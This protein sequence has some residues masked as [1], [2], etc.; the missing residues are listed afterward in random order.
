MHL[1]IRTLFCALVLALALPACLEIEEEVEVAADGSVE[2]V[3]R[4]RGDAADLLEGYPVPTGGAWVA[5]D[6]GTAGWLAGGPPPVHPR[7]PDEVAVAVRARFASLADLPRWCA[8]DGEPYRTAGEERVT[9]LEV[10]RRGARTVY[11]FER[12]YPVKARELWNVKERIDEELPEELAN[13]LDEGHELL[14]SE[15]R[16]V[17]S[18]VQNVWGGAIGGAAHDALLAVY[19]EGRAELS[20]DGFQATRDAVRG[21]I[22][23]AL[24]EAC[25]RG[26]V[27]FV[28]RVEAEGGDDV[29]VPPEYDFDRVAR[30]AARRALP[31]ALD[32]AGLAPE[33]ANAVLE[34]FEWGLSAIDRATDRSDETVRLRVRLPGTIVGGNFDTLRAD[35]RAEWELEGDVAWRDHELVLRAVSVLE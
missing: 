19:L 8:P 20:V 3:V 24:D 27:A 30:D 2:V 26:F 29:D 15:W 14:P 32:Q 11:V 25:V 4:A 34:R 35:G 22:E 18:G 16:R 17:V 9:S 12:R 31:L 21:E 6:A 5:D 13:A 33:V 10:L 23:R 28:R 7:E 1:P